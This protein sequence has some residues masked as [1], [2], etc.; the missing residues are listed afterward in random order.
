MTMFACVLP[1]AASVVGLRHCPFRTHSR[2]VL[3]SESLYDEAANGDE[4]DLEAQS[5]IGNCGRT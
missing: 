5:I 4:G 1:G 3:A 2:N